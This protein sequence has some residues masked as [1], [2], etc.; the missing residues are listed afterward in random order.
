MR[1][2]AIAVAVSAHACFVHTDG[3]V[4][5]I[6]EGHAGQLGD[7]RSGPGYRQPKPIKVEGLSDIVDIAAGLAFSCA[8][9]K[10]GKL[11]CW[12]DNG[13]GQLGTGDKRRHPRPVE[14]PALT[15]VTAVA[16]GREHA[17]ALRLDQSVL[18]WGKSQ[19]GQVGDGTMGI[20]K[21]VLTP[22]L[23]KL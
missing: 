15:D 2:P 11:F 8:V 12:G 18:C 3:S 22:T 19:S 17:C 16:L 23:A 7:G 13:W 14:V 10:D 21:A 1:K 20:G 6:G 9:R 4:S 5:C